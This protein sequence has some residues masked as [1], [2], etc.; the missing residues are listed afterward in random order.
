[1][2]LVAG[3]LGAFAGALAGGLVT[4]LTARAQMRRDLE[5]AYDRELRTQRMIAYRSL[6]ART[7]VLPRYWRENPRRRVLADWSQSFHEWYFTESGGLFLSD[8]ARQTYHVA[9]EVIAE[10]GTAGAPDDVLTAADEERLWRAG[11]AL[12]RTLAADLGTARAPQV[13][14]SEPLRT[15]PAR[16]RIGRVDAPGPG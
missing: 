5:Y 10:I 13:P 9:L 4:F 14:G 8:A 11:Q 6:Y 1:M 16:S 12:R 3:L 2:E 7:V 15:S